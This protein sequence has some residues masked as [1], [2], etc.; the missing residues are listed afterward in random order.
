MTVRRDIVGLS[1]KIDMFIDAHYIERRGSG[2][3][4]QTA[5]HTKQVVIEF[6]GRADIQLEMTNKKEV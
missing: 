4:K 6:Q 1:N 3:A 5:V 2:E